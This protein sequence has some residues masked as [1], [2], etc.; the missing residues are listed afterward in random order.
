MNKLR[1]RNYYKTSFLYIELFF[2]H[3]GRLSPPRRRGSSNKSAGFPFSREFCLLGEDRTEC[4]N[5]KLHTERRNE[6]KFSNQI[7]ISAIAES[8][9]PKQD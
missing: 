1:C 3:A 8:I 5:D 2:C 4:R 6:V 9:K 7:G